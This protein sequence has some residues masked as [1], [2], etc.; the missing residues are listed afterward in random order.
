MRGQEVEREHGSASA[1]VAAAHCEWMKARAR[2][3][4]YDDA[5]IS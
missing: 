1:C 4:T 5:M 2:L 3:I